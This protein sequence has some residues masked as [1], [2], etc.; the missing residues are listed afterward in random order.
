MEHW[1]HQRVCPGP[2]AALS[3]LIFI[4]VAA[5]VSA[6][7]SLKS[8]RDIA[9]GNHPVGAIAVDFDGDGI[10]DVVSVDQ[11]D[12]TLGL[13]KGFGDGTFRRVR[14]LAVG[15]LPSAVAFADTNGDGLPDLITANLRSQEV[16]VNLNDGHGGYGA[17]IS[18]QVLGTT[19]S[20]MAVGDWNGD[21]KIDVAVIAGSLNTLV[22]MTGDGAGHFGT[23]LQYTVG[24]YPKLVVTA[25]FNRDAKADLAVVNNTSASIQIWRGDG[26]GQF[27][28]TT[29]LATGTGTSPQGLT[30]GDLDNDGDAD[31][32]VCNYGTDTVGVYLNNGSGGFGSPTLLSPGFG[33]RAAVVADVNKDGKPDLFVTLSKVSGVGQA[34]TFLGNGTGGFGAPSVVNTGPVPNTATQGDFNQDGNLDLVTVNLTGNTLSILQ[35]T[36]SGAFLLG[37]KVALA[38]GAYP[39]GVVAADL[40]RDGRPDLASANQAQG[41]VSVAYG[42]GAGGFSAPSSPVRTGTTPTAIVAADYNRDGNVDL[43]TANNGTND[44][45]YLQ[46]S[47]TSFGTYS[48]T[49]GCTGPVSIA[50]DD[51]SG[52][53]LSDLAVV[54]EGSSQMCTRRGTGSSGNGAF[55]AS[56]C[57]L[58]GGIPTDLTLGNF[59][60]DAFADAAI[61]FSALGSVSVALSNG[62]GGVSGTPASIP[63]GL[64]PFGMA[65]G[66]VNGDGVVDIVVTNSGSNSITVLLGGGTGAPPIESPAGL[67]PTA[68]VLAD[69]NLDGTI[70]AAVA[71]TDDNNVSLLLGDGTGRFLSAGYFGTR[72]LPVALGAGDFNSDG[73]PDLAVADSFSDSL[74]ILLN[75]S[76]AGDPL[77]WVSM[78][79]GERNVFRWG[80]VPGAVYDVIRGSIKS[81]VPQPDSV[82]LGPVVCV[83]NDIA[84]T[85]TTNY[86]DS[87]NPAETQAFFYLVRS[88]VGG[89][90]GNY[91]VASNGKVGSPSSGDCN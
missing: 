30:A 5:P 53:L 56:V 18:S 35:N 83:G 8:R 80:M 44:M 46:G 2:T 38:S 62:A 50:T 58:L 71:N 19:M 21:G 16:T 40:N 54:C 68:L 13:V 33:P 74:T 22:V 67:A 12:D 73:K 4:L 89:V 72:D 91:T 81:I 79:G 78:F 61:S 52:D 77:Q 9:T 28:L 3:L 10:L 64:Q 26:T 85:D 69:F 57:T 34:A 51:I 48:F 63:V 11:L 25:D 76:M 45:T 14:G 65:T 87:A 70:D 66:D 32:V 15:S 6:Q 75:Q 49:T 90:P 84:E 59:N 17:K 20:G 36:G 60:G 24:T 1:G 41:N 39:Q 88:V 47:G 7:S 82:D 86:P 29:T 55:G 42:D 31:L 37:S 43:V 27:T 23:P